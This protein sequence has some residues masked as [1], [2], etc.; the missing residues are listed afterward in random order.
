[1]YLF[2]PVVH[3][4]LDALTLMYATLIGFLVDARLDAIEQTVITT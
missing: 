4:W 3:G 1:M 2:R